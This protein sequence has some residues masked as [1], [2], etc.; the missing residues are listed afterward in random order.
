MRTDEG[1]WCVFVGLAGRAE[2]VFLPK[3]DPSI[4]DHF[5]FRVLGPL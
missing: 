1:G 2:G 3:G 4:T 5:N